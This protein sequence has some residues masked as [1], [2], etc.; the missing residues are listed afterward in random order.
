MSPK[1]QAALND[2]RAAVA[3]GQQRIAPAT[4]SAFHGAA[5]TSAAFRIAKAQ[6]LLE[7]AYQS[8]VGTPVYRAAGTA[9][10]IAEAAAAVKH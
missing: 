9:A 4:F 5:S 3:G 1:T 2:I 10:A 6:G 8:C 7:V